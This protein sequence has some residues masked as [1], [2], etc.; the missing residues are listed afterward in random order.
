MFAKDQFSWVASERHLPTLWPEQSLF[1]GVISRAAGLF[2]FIKTVALA[3]ERCEDPTACLKAILQDTT[4][5]G[6]TPLFN[7]ATL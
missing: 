3:L 1:D 4:D 2:I 5:T 7:H 6:M